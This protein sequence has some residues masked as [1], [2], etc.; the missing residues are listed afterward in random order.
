MCARLAMGGGERESLVARSE[1]R[2]TGHGEKFGRRWGRHA[3]KVARW[4]GHHAAQFG[5]GAWPQQA[6]SI[7]TAARQRHAWAARLCLSRVAP[8]AV[9]AWALAG[10]GRGREER[11]TGARGPT[12]RKR[13]VG[14]AQMNSEDF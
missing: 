3:F 1:R 6:G 5:H 2:V 14:R 7:L 9:D 8:G 12:R 4:G 13:E 10:S 11:G